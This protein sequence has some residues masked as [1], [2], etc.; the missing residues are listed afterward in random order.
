[1][2]LGSL[3]GEH[4]QL[5][6]G[7][8]LRCGPQICSCLNNRQW[9]QSLDEAREEQAAICLAIERAA[10]YHALLWPQSIGERTEPRRADQPAKDG[11]H[12]GPAHVLSLSC[13][14]K[15]EVEISASSGMLCEAASLDQ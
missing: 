1:M 4:R 8:P 2:L 15:H 5:K 3:A 12:V 13:L 14:S 10:P 11:P 6:C 7:H 9:S